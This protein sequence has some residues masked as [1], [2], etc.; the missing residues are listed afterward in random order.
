MWMARWN[1]RRRALFATAAPLV[2]LASL[3]SAVFAHQRLADLDAA[4]ALRA[5]SL[6]R[7][8]AAASE[9]PTLNG[10]SEVLQRL[11]AAALDEEDVIDVR[12]VDANGRPLVAPEAAAGSLPWPA[13]ALPIQP[14]SHFTANS[15]Y[16]VEP[17]RTL[18]AELADGFGHRGDLA[19]SAQGDQGLVLLELARQGV[20]PIHGQELKQ[21][22]GAGGAILFTCLLLAL[23]LNRS[24]AAPTSAAA[25]TPPSGAR[26]RRFSGASEVTDDADVRPRGAGA[27]EVRN[28]QS[29]SR[30]AARRFL[31][32]RVE[33][34]ERRA[35]ASARQLATASHDLRQPLHALGLFIA[36]LAQQRLDARSRRL[37]ERLAAA[38]AA[39]NRLLDSLLDLSRLDCG[40]LQ[41]R[42]CAFALQPLLERI[43]AGHAD[44]AQHRL[45]LRLRPCRHWVHS[46]PTLLE[47]ILGNLLDNAVAHTDGGTV[48][49]ACR[50][51]GKQLRI[52]IRDSGPGI[53]LGAQTQ[54]F[55]DFVR[56]NHAGSSTAGAHG[57]GLGLPIVR[58]LSALL[59]HRLSLHSAPGH[60]TVFAIEVPLATPADETLEPIGD[61][62]L[63]EPLREL[64]VAVIDADVRAREALCG[65][66][67]SWGCR[68]SSAGC[69]S[70]LATDLGHGVDAPRLLIADPNAGGEDRSALLAQLG[71]QGHGLKV[72]LLTADTRPQTLARARAN[73][74]PLLTKP[75]QPA[76]LRALMQRMATASA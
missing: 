61:H 73:G 19:G 31:H 40:R 69:A 13:D 62:A 9:Y 17:I 10:L 29:R 72:I 53:A 1:V 75:V 16:V 21:A 58:R 68:V 24:L 47:R 5:R 65:L 44:A 20:G 55:E 22:V 52:E 34:A 7:Q 43:V 51:R 60:G 66:L 11:A 41:P 2:L 33:E 76:R 50:R 54:I 15:L 36:E 70:V 12:F 57:L 59:Q 3:I 64:P 27:T 35:S 74:M 39:S 56:L 28:R 37:V 6:A 63:C 23:M 46:D 30:V 49:L 4:Q 8:L 45:R 14:W 38:S 71:S 32:T 25:E 18:P 67:T 26:I 42:P 48:L